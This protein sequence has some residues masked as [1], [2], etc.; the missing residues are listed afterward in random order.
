MKS[1]NFIEV[2]FVNESAIILRGAELTE[3]QITRD[4]PEKAGVTAGR[5]STPAF[6]A[7]RATLGG[8]FL[9]SYPIVR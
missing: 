5:Y 3:L 1:E 8:N 7:G 4:C 6:A 2:E 9:A